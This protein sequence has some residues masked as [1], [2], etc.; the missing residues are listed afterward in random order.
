VLP[1]TSAWE[2]TNHFFLLTNRDNADY[3]T[4]HLPG[5]WLAS[6][7]ETSEGRKLDVARIKNLSG[8]DAVTAQLK[9][10]NYFSFQSTA[11]LILV[12][13]HRPH[14]PAG[15]DAFWRR[16]VVVP[17][18]H[19]IPEER[20]TKNLAEMIIRTEGPGILNWM[21]DGARLWKKQGLKATDQIRSAID[22]YRSDEDIVGNFL[23]DRYTLSPSEREPK[24][25][26]VREFGEYCKEEG[27]KQWSTKLLRQEL[28][29]FNVSVALDQRHFVGLSQ[30][31]IL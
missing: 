18:V 11:K 22:E 24:K 27:I 14:V 13:N 25:D 31:Q 9:Y 12:T 2:H 1:V 30:A 19:Q 8:E 20:R 15:D 16:V 21:I 7:V 3:V 23:R 29:R 28:K 10:Q 17:F 26:V 6:C 5:I 4:G